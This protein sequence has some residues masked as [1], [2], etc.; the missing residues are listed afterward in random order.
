[1]FNKFIFNFALLILFSINQASSR[2]I[3]SNYNNN[4]VSPFTILEAI[5]NSGGVLSK[6]TKKWMKKWN[7]INLEDSS[8]FQFNELSGSTSI[9]LKI[10][11]I[12]LTDP[13]GYKAYGSFLTVNE[14]GNP[15]SEIA[16]FNLAAIL[17]V[18]R[19][20]RPAIRYELG[21]VA[22]LAFM[23]LIKASSI[24]GQQRSGNKKRILRA[25]HSGSPLLGCIKAKKSE[26]TQSYESMTK[27]G[28]KSNGS[29]SP[30]DS[31]VKFIQA[32]KQQP[33]SGDIVFLKKNYSGDALELSREFSIL[34]TLDSIFG[35][36]D[37][38]SGGNITLEKDD[39]EMAHFVAVD[40]GGAEI[41][42]SQ[43]LVKKTVK[44]FSR[45]DRNVINK[46]QEF[47][48]FLEYPSQP[49]LG[50]TSP[51]KIIVDMGMYFLKSPAAYLSAIKANIKI[52]LNEV[53][54]NENR[55][56]ANAYF[57]D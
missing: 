19:M 20:F 13:K 23:K 35:Q 52:L 42:D 27:S 38:F 11:K 2:E 47:Y 6:N 57:R 8:K 31:I 28:R 26:S 54:N 44:L 14:S 5:E 37:R 39:L 22:S 55:Y 46:I 16:Y 17:G 12:D 4:F 21:P 30:S 7:Q 49:F 51:E 15:N 45:Y 25:I 29:L 34:L 33:I 10:Q 36:Y 48:Q 43:Y 18:D 41:V 40:N 24:N 32:S 50:Y 3:R 56:G 53:Q 1:M 9:N